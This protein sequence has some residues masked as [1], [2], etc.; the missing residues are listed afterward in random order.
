MTEIFFVNSQRDQVKDFVSLYEETFTEKPGFIEAI[1]YDTAIILFETIGR[2]DIHFRS[3][4]KHEFLKLRDF[5][6]VTGPTEFDEN[7]EAL[8]RL[9]LLQ[10]S[11][12]EF[13][14][15]EH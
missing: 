3:S 6:G 4:I 7:G 13:I 12:N 5:E 15:L 10:I 11:G 9:Y 2:S 8:K 14:E 1:S